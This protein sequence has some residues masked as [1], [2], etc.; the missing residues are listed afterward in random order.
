MYHVCLT[1]KPFALNETS[2]HVMVIDETDFEE[3][4][5]YLL[6]ATVTDGIHNRYG[7]SHVGGG[8]GK[9]HC[10]LV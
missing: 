10:Q 4:I 1:I 7:M 2:G 5:T 3:K 6:N 9:L 8:G